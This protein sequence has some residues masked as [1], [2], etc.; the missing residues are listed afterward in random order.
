VGVSD[1]LVGPSQAQIRPASVCVDGRVAPGSL[2]APLF[3][4]KVMPFV[5]FSDG[6]AKTYFIMFRIVLKM[7]F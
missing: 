3:R 1:S 5:L 4:T 2:R 7:H 6:V